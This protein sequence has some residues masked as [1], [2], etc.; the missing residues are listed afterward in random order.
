M[1]NQSEVLFSSTLRIA[2][3]LTRRDLGKKCE[4]LEEVMKQMGRWVKVSNVLEPKIIEEILRKTMD[5]LEDSKHQM[6]E[7]I[8]SAREEHK[9]ILVTLEELKRDIHLII[10]EVDRLEIEFR[11]TRMHLAEVN[12]NHSKFTEQEKTRVY[13]QADRIREELAI[14]R[15]R[16]KNLHKRR[17]DQEQSLLRI[18]K[19]VE[20]AEQTVGQVGV[21]LD[22]LCGNIAEIN[23]QLESIQVRY[24]L[25]QKIIKIQEEE[26][27]RV[28]REIHDGPAQNLANVVLKA[29]ICE[30][31][32]QDGR[33]NDLKKELL[34]L[35]EAV[36]DSLRE[37]RKIIH[38][39]RPMVLDD[40]G[41]VP[42]I[43]RL[44]EEIES[45]ESQVK[46]NILVIGKETR[47][48]TTIEIAVYRVI[49]EALN[50][51]RKYAEATSTQ[52]KLEFLDDRISAVIEDDGVGFDSRLINERLVSGDHFGLYG[53]RER[54]ELL[55]GSFKVR[56]AP[57]K[58]TRVTIIIPLSMN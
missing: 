9:R 5:V 21:A 34:E 32:I 31:L 15:E 13:E 12:Q 47:L 2:N 33:D 35:K 3:L 27:K 1:F 38:N 24:Q 14:V 22:F 49:Q 25:G 19:L 7:I 52:V 37:V 40:L 17:F 50:N 53:M 20:K 29:E 56:T 26:R 4:N 58:G 45:G 6:F 46:I 42:A 55:G 10:T 28:A 41:L 43:K 57:G 30:Q 16:E 36:R 44:A 48:D 8:E 51:S 11:R 39:L 54:V 18:A 23:T